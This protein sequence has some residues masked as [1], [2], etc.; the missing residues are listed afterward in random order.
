MTGPSDAFTGQIGQWVA[1]IRT[2]GGKLAGPPWHLKPFLAPVA[3]KALQPDVRI[4]VTYDETRRTAAGFPYDGPHFSVESLGPQRLY[5]RLSRGL[6]VL[7]HTGERRADVTV[8]PCPLNTLGAD[9]AFRMNLRGAIEVPLA[10]LCPEL[11]GML[12]HA[13]A[14]DIPG[15]GAVML[16]G[17]SG[18]GKSTN[19]R[20]AMDRGWTILGDDRV[21]LQFTPDGPVAVPSP[22]VSEFRT[23]S[24]GSGAMFPLK[25][26]GILHRAETTGLVPLTAAQAIPQILRHAVQHRSDPFANETVLDM[27]IALAS[28]ARV[29]DYRAAFTPE[30]NLDIWESTLR[31]A[32]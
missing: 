16:L 5:A 17:T 15:I 11:G 18:A 26:I 27:V 25:A 2:R 14:F 29:F 21:L 22:F 1:R 13:S 10:L 20:W 4:D 8:S 3:D 30:T 31:S 7:L 23:L 28:A 12:F 6:E 9:D 24:A 19:A 32:V